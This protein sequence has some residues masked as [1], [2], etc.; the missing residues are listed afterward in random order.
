MTFMVC[1]LAGSSR[2][3]VVFCH[4]GLVAGFGALLAIQ[5]MGIRLADA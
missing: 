5:Q 2:L 4:V 1:V 3:F